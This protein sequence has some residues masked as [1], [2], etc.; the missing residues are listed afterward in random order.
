MAGSGAVSGGVPA[1]V[2]LDVI[3]DLTGMP[4][5]K[6]TELAHKSGTWD[7]R[8][9]R[10]PAGTAN[11]LTAAIPS[12]GWRRLSEQ[13]RNAGIDMSRASALLDNS[14]FPHVESERGARLVQA[15]WL[16]QID[17]VAATA[18]SAARVDEFPLTTAQSPVLS[19]FGRITADVDQPLP[20]VEEPVLL[21]DDLDDEPPGVRAGFKSGLGLGSGDVDVTQRISAVASETGAQMRN[22]LA[23]R[24]FRRS[25]GAAILL[26]APFLAAKSLQSQ[27]AIRRRGDS[28]VAYLG[29]LAGTAI[30]GV[31]LLV[32][33]HP[34]MVHAPGFRGAGVALLTGS[35]TPIVVPELWRLI[36]GPSPE[37]QTNQSTKGKR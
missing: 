19:G 17:V 9:D 30:T 8:K 21:V 16:K 5:E 3:A 15:D 11:T 26:G 2:P 32:R 25:V 28:N 6:V 34:R 14:G 36:S 23:A 4:H 37:P 24:E 18:R 22:V 12:D 20:I 35:L 10:V 31:T 1:Y 13:A 27:D 33:T 29:V 7:A